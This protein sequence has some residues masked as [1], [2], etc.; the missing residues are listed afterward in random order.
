M[1]SLYRRDVNGRHP[2]LTFIG[3]A[4]FLIEM[5]HMGVDP[6]ARI[7]LWVTALA[8]L[9]CAMRFQIAALVNLLRGR[10]AD[11]TPLAS[12]AD[13]GSHAGGRTAEG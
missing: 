12:L 1:F 6:V 7:E 9:A 4:I 13:D 10:R 2:P 11:G 5:T 3:V 8:C